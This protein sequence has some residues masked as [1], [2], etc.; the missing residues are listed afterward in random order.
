METNRKTS[1]ETAIEFIQSI[2]KSLN[3]KFN[4]IE[5]NYI[6]AR[7]TFLDPRLKKKKF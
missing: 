3:D 4:N 1:N 7:A 5:H 6:V 2:Y